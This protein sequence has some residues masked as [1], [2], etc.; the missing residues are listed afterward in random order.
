MQT[1]KLDVTNNLTQAPPRRREPRTAN[2][3]LSD[4]QKLIE[5]EV[6]PRLARS[7][8]PT[9]AASNWTVAQLANVAVP[10]KARDSSGTLL[11]VTGLLVEGDR[12][13]IRG[14]LRI[15]AK[16]PTLKS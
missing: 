14:G 9:S 16:V 12:V 8:L 1:A 10:I 15:Y 2:R 4:Y 13:A 3:E 7:G 6:E 11:A 5:D